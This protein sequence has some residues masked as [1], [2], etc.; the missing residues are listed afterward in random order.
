MGE[1]GF[2]NQISEISGAE[3]ARTSRNNGKTAV[4][5]VDHAAFAT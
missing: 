5:S 3:A 1:N 4:I 2:D